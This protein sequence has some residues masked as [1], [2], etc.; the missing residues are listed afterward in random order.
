MYIIKDYE[1]CIRRKKEPETRTNMNL[2]SSSVYR[3]EDVAWEKLGSQEDQYSQSQNVLETSP[4]YR[5]SKEV[6]HA[7][8]A[9]TILKS[10][11]T[12]TRDASEATQM[13]SSHTL[14]HQTCSGKS[15]S[16]SRGTGPV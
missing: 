3:I 9:R 11:D 10:P 4:L 1:A 15:N 7:L 13:M 16:V 8:D 6:V 2:S 5:G 12:T 14:G